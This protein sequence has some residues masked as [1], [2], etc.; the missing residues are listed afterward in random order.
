M[1]ISSTSAKE[2]PTSSL[3]DYH[4]AVC[5]EQSQSANVVICVSVSTAFERA[6]IAA[7]AGSGVAAA[8]Q[9]GPQNS[10]DARS[11]LG[12]IGRTASPRWL[13]AQVIA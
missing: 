2:R 9:D 5:I 6:P 8:R 13:A 12:S 7:N 4:G 10:V 1:R 3:P 11:R